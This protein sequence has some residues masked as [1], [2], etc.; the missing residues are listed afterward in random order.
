MLALKDAELVA[1]QQEFEVFLLIGPS[2]DGH[3]VEQKSKGAR[4]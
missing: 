1:K 3:H 4:E 2:Q